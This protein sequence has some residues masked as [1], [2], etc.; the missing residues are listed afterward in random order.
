MI[1]IENLKE[2]MLYAGVEGKSIAFMLVDTQIVNESFL[3]DVNNI[4]N[5]GQVPN[6]FASD[7]YNKICE[8]LRPVMKKDGIDTRDGL[9]KAFLN[10]VRT[11]LHIVLCHSPVGDALRVRCREFPSLINCTT[12]DWFNQWPVEALTAAPTAL[13][14]GLGAI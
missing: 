6:M 9:R 8:D 4:L 10:R 7:E 5:T 3:E 11:N 2:I 12:I 13:G 1:F 14:A